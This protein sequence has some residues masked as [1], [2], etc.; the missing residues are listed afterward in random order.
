[1]GNYS[2][3]GQKKDDPKSMVGRPMI[4]PIIFCLICGVL[5]IL[6]RKDAVT[7]TAYVLAG[8][9]LLCGVWSV[10]AYK[11]SEPV[12]RISGAR[13]AIG[14]ILLVAGALLAFNPNLLEVLLPKIWGLA[15]IFGGFLKIQYAFDEKSVGVSKWWIML[16]LAAFSIFIGILSL[17]E[18]A[19]LG[20]NDGKYLAIGIMLV[21]EAVLDIIVFFLLKYALMKAEN[22][23]AAAILASSGSPAPDEPEPS[24][25]EESSDESDDSGSSGASVSEEP[26]EPEESASESA[27]PQDNK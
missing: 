5:L 14:L 25:D 8:V 10:I 26:E 19:F 24:G 20:V 18:P 1:M 2:F 15:L 22:E 27:P 21:A 9:M 7:I 6:I 3:V 13:L 23:K 11:R 17:V 16:I 12:Q 4:L